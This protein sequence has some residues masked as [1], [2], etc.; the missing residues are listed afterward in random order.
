MKCI[1][2]ERIFAVGFYKTAQVRFG[3][4]AQV[5]RMALPV[6]NLNGVKVYNLS[7]GKSLPQWLENT[8]SVRALR[9]NQGNCYFNL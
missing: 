6:S 9:Y 3:F 5:L 8:K 1:H 7:A 2:K 4:S